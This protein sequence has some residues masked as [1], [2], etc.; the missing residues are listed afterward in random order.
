VGVSLTRPLSVRL[1]LAVSVGCCLIDCARAFERCAGVGI[2]VPIRL[3]PLMWGRGRHSRVNGGG[4][5]NRLDAS[6]RRSRRL[7]RCAVLGVP[8][9]RPRLR[10]A[11]GVG[12]GSGSPVTPIRTAPEQSTFAC[13]SI[14]EAYGSARSVRSIAL[15]DET[16]RVSSPRQSSSLVRR[17]CSSATRS[18]AGAG[19]LF[20]GT[21]TVSSV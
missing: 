10:R 13:Q 7:V 19:E 6:G 17:R 9:I 21:T 11:Q 14:R 1:A 3:H 18:T 8:I 2:G 12:V 16:F 4:L 5:S 20:A 15:P